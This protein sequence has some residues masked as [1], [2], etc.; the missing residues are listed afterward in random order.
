[1]VPEKEKRDSEEAETD[2]LKSWRNIAEKE[3]KRDD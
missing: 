1:M 2:Y 3:V